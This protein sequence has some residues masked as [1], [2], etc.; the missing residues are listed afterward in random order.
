LIEHQVGDHGRHL[1]LAADMAAGMA[2]DMAAGMAFGVRRAFIG[3]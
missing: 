1:G 2:A 3:L